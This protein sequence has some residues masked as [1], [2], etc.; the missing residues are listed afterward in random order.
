MNLRIV[1]V[2]VN[3]KYNKNKLNDKKKKRE[4]KENKQY[5]YVR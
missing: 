2:C 4:R 1:G 5:L 3:N